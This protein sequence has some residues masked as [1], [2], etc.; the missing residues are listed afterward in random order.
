MADLTSLIS[1]IVALIALLVALL[2]ALQQYSATA[3]GYRRCQRSVMGDWAKHTHRRFKWRQ[4]EFRFETVFAVPQI[5]L[6]DDV[7]KK[8]QVRERLIPITKSRESLKQIMAPPLWKLFPSILAQKNPEL[9]GFHEYEEEPVS[10]S[11]S[12]NGLKPWVWIREYSLQWWVWIRSW[13]KTGEAS[14]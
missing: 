10:T 8:G 7:D 12:K 6:F 2:Q 1:L 4:G 3:D 9:Y 11:D 13:T 14:F 5:L